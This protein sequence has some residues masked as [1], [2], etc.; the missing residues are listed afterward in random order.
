MYLAVQAHFWA[1]RY[2]KRGADTHPRE[3]GKRDEDDAE[4]EDEGESRH[5][6]ETNTWFLENSTD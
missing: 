5:G 3:D 1:E 2:A 4:E 6:A